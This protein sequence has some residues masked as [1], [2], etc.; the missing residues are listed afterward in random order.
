MNISGGKH[1]GMLLSEYFDTSSLSMM[2]KLPILFLLLCTPVG[3]CKAQVAKDT[4]FISFNN[5]TDLIKKKPGTKEYIWLKNFQYE[6]EMTAYNQAIEK[7]KKHESDSLFL[8]T[9]ISIFPTKPR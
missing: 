1:C 4:V 6:K 8:P 7:F 5:G 9:T 2:I 3:L